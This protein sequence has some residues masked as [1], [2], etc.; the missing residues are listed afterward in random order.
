MPTPASRATLCCQTNVTVPLAGPTEHP[1]RELR[2]L[3]RALF[4]VDD[5]DFICFVQY[6]PE[7][8]EHPDYTTALNV[9]RGLA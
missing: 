4:V 7:V 5:E 8:Q 9:L 2:I 1:S 3:H 6:L